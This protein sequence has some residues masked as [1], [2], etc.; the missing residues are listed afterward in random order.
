MP[1]AHTYFMNQISEAQF[2]QLLSNALFDKQN[3]YMENVHDMEA[4]L[5]RAGALVAQAGLKSRV[6]DRPSNPF[7]S[8]H[9]SAISSIPIIGLVWTAAMAMM[10]VMSVGRPTA[11]VTFVRTADHSLSVV[12]SR[13]MRAGKTAESAGGG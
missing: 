6:V 2:A 13:K 5:L 7:P 8:L 1:F 12:F 4:T 3:F 11:D 9:H 10:A